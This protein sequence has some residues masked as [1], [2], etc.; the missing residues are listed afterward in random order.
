MRALFGEGRHPDAA[1]SSAAAVADGATADAGVAGAALGRAF[2]VY[3][4]EPSRYLQLVAARC[5]EWNTDRDLPPNRPVPAEVKARIRTEIAREL[6]AEQHGRPPAD[7]RE[8]AG[9]IA[10]ESR[11]ATTAV[12]GYDLTFSPVKSVSALCGRSPRGP[13][14]TQI[15]AAHHAAVADT[16]GWL[17]REAAF[18]RDGPGRACG[19]SPVRGL[20]AAAF[21]HRDSRAGDPDLHTHVAVSNKVQTR[22]GRW[23]A[24]DGRALHKAKVA[25]SEHYNTRL[26]ALLRAAARRHVHRT[27]RPCGG[28]AAGARDRRGRPAAGRPLVVAAP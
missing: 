22:D 25:A 13:V 19:R 16:L 5:A 4:T 21:T 7:A 28:Q 24:L 27:R 8:L 10:R 15:E 20:I 12:A 26:E 1:R 17:E 2:A 14:A 11:Q 3:A 23:L 6:F 18:T 9:F